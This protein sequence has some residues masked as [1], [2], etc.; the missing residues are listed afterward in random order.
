MHEAVN[1]LIIGDNDYDISCDVPELKTFIVDSLFVP[2]DI[3]YTVIRDFFDKKDLNYD[4]LG[5][6]IIKKTQKHPIA[7]IETQIFEIECPDSLLAV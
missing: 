3:L 2:T 5:I 1:G 7:E 4:E 6:K